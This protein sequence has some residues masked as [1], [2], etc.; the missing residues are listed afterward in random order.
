MGETRDFL[1][2]NFSYEGEFYPGSKQKRRDL[3]PEPTV[4]ERPE[5]DVNSYIK[6]IKGVST[7]M[8]TIEALCLGL[9]RPAVTIRLWIRKGYIPEAIYRLPARTVNGK[10]QKGRR[11]YTREQVEAVLK[12]FEAHGIRQNVRVDWSKHHPAVDLEI[13][14]A[15]LELR[16]QG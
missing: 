12:V 1:D 15:W 5:W 2:E 7:E 16:K 10:A 3:E 13:A 4:E 11:L 6:V 14:A 9:S 8:F